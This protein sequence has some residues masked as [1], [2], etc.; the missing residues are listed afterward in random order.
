MY[1]VIYHDNSIGLI[2][3]EQAEKIE[4]FRKQGMYNRRQLEW[5]QTVKEII[6]IRQAPNHRLLVKTKDMVCNCKECET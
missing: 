4:L 5:L 6:K 2:K 1:K 3:D